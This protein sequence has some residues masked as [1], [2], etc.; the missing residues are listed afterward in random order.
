[1][2]VKNHG[3]LLVLAEPE[4]KN[5]FADESGAVSTDEVVLMGAVIGLALLAIGNFATG[6][7]FLANDRREVLSGYQG[8]TSTASNDTSSSR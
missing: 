8:I 4:K 1:M 2:T 6:A 3:K 7:E 5:F